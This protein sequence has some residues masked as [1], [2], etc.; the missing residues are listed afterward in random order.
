MKKHNEKYL[1]TRDD[2]SRKNYTDN[3]DRIFGKACRGETTFDLEA[4]HE[5]T[6]GTCRC[7][8]CHQWSK[9]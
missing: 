7:R 5:E 3:F 2:E 8:A 6:K 1:N 4:Q 9:R